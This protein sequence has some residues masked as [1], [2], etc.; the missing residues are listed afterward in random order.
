MRHWFYPIT[1]IESAAIEGGKRRFSSPVRE[2]SA[3]KRPMTSSAARESS[4]ATEKLVIDITS[5][6]GV[7]KTVKPKP[8]KPGAPKATVSIAERLA[9]RKGSTVPPVSGFV[10]KH[11]SGAKFESTSERL[12]AM[13][14][15]KVDSVAK[16]APGPIPYS[17]VIDS[18]AEIR[19]S[20]RK[21]KR[22]AQLL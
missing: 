16:V 6:K 13:K 14:S 2:P 20:R 9:Q 5:P 3:K 18:S 4:S 10:S 19:A 11:P 1:A 21:Q 15:G 17:V 22:S 7:K 8:M 12:V